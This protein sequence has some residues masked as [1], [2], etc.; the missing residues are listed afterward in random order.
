MR[1]DLW[2]SLVDFLLHLCFRCIMASSGSGGPPVFS[3]ERLKTL[4]YLS[5]RKEFED[6]LS[7]CADGSLLLECLYA[8][9]AEGANASKK[10]RDR[11]VLALIRNACS[12]EVRVHVEDSE[13]AYEAW[14]ALEDLI[15]SHCTTNVYSLEKASAQLRK[16]PS[17]SIVGFVARVRQHRDL[18]KLAGVER[19]DASVVH[20]ILDGLPSDYDHMRDN[21]LFGTDASALATVKIMDVMSRLQIKEQMLLNA[22]EGDSRHQVPANATMPTTAP[23]PTAPPMNVKSCTYC[24]KAGH[25]AKNCFKRKRDEARQNRQSDQSRAT[26]SDTVAPTLPTRA[27]AV[28]PD[29]NVGEAQ[30]SVVRFDPSMWVVDSGAGQHMCADRS[31]FVNYQECHFEVLCADSSPSPVYGVGEVEVDFFGFPI[32]LHNV[33]FVPALAQ[34]L[35]SVT[36]ALDRGAAVSFTS[37]A[38]SITFPEGDEHAF[39]LGVDKVFKLYCRTTL[40]KE[41]RG[42]AKDAGAPHESQTKTE[43]EHTSPCLATTS[44]PDATLWH[45]R[46]AHL[47]TDAVVALQKHG[48]VTGMGDKPLTMPDHSCAVCVSAEAKRHPFPVSESRAS[49]PRA[50]AHGPDW[51]YASFAQ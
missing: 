7:A 39:H 49:Q 34:N 9:P 19:T 27:L 29:G 8:V 48:F 37:G 16:K 22:R 15:S 4:N 32:M 3:G 50:A 6:F 30:L 13:T 35:F 17:E 43:P 46:F 20:V 31:L 51:P 47:S 2:V 21:Y 28:E 24:H 25:V 45:R 1:T 38:G 41:K 14:T 11:K 40:G 23:P 33:A 18:L 26:P 36:A 5:W 42:V 44:S 12:R 10:A